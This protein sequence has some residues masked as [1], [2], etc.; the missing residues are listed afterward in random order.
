MGQSVTSTTAI[1]NDGL[2]FLPDLLSHGLKNCI[3]HRCAQIAVGCS[4]AAHQTALRGTSKINPQLAALTPKVDNHLFLRG[5]NALRIFPGRVSRRGMSNS[6]T[7]TY[8]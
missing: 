5:K 1:I 7:S 2:K 3:A 8:A 4:R 6:P